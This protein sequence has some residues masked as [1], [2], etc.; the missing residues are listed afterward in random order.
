MNVWFVHLVLASN[1]FHTVYSGLFSACAYKPHLQVTMHL[2]GSVR[3]IKSGIA[4]AT[5][6][7][8]N[9]TRDVHV[10]A[11]PVSQTERQEDSDM[12]HTIF[13]V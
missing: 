5:P 3:L 1:N 11:K 2:T 9:P 6:S 12:P 8:L 4:L 13:F 10:T 7:K